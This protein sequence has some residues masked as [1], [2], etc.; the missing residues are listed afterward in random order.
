MIEP[1]PYRKQDAEPIT[2][3]MANCTPDGWTGAQWS[4]RIGERVY[5]DEIAEFSKVVK[6]IIKIC[7]DFD[8]IRKYFGKHGKPIRHEGMDPTLA[9]IIDSRLMVYVAEA[10]GP[11]F[12]IEAYRKEK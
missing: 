9:F 12:W 3:F 8:A 11:N 2:W 10:T 1:L 4:R 7:P 5:P 6:E